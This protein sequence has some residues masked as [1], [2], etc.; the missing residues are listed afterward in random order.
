MSFNVTL[1]GPSGVGKTSLAD[2][3]L[4]KSFSDSHKPTVGASMVK[5]PLEED[6]VVTWFFIWDTA[7]MEQYRSLAPIYYR[8]SQC[9]ILVYDISKKTSLEDAE[10]WLKL[11]RQECNGTYPVVAIGNKIDL[12]RE[13][14]EDEE[15]EFAARNEVELL[16]ASAKTGE[17]VDQILPLLRKK[18]T[19]V[20]LPEDCKSNA[21]PIAD[22]VPYQPKKS[23]C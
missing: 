10:S 13:I 1:I 9:A 21:I 5:I 3:I 23:C 4:N 17:G 20:E 8:D 7:G 22:F 6:D 11:Y 2:A 15:K 18:L 14:S 19:L 16:S 12:E